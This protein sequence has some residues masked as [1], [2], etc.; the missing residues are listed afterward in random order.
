MNNRASEFFLF[1]CNLYKV[2]QKVHLLQLHIP[3]IRQVK[4]FSPPPPQPL[5]G[6]IFH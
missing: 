4:L 3:G 1:C 2:I 6:F 5:T